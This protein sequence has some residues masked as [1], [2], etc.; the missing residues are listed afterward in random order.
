MFKNPSQHL[1]SAEDLERY[2]SHQNNAEDPGYRKFLNKLLEPLKTFLP[3]KF[4]AIDFGCGPGPV[5]AMMLRELGGTVMNFDPVFYQDRSLLEGKYD[6]VT[7]TEV[8][9]HFKEPSTDWRVLVN[10]V[11]P[12]GLLGIMTQFLKED[13]DYMTWWYKNDPTHVAF[14]NAKTFT[15]L[16]ETFGLEK[17]FDDNNSVI[18]FRKKI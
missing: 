9:E 8:V 1:N 2:S 7:S 4:T 10:L 15:Y 12:G 5:L 3:E 14:Y 6:V 18:I 17:L 11:A 13:T 16:E